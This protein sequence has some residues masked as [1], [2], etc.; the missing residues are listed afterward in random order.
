MDA[1][2]LNH[3]TS[4]MDSDQ[5]GTLDGYEM[6]FPT[7]L[8]VL[9]TRVPLVGGDGL[10]HTEYSQLSVFINTE[11]MGDTDHFVQGGED[12]F[13]QGMTPEMQVLLNDATLYDCE[14]GSGG[15]DRAQHYAPPVWAVLRGF[16]NL[17]GPEVD[18]FVSEEAATEHA[19]A[20]TDAVVREETIAIE[21]WGERPEEG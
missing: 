7:G 16:E 20:F 13:A 9:V 14:P 12:E 17:D 11:D 2:T 8:R 10:T 6:E 19:K 18:L 4:R 5:V 1:P 3:K 15:K 21:P